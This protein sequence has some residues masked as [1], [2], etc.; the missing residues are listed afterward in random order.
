MTNRISPQTQKTVLMIAMGVVAAS[1]LAD[2]FGLN[3]PNFLTTKI[4]GLAN[5]L[6]IGA[7][8]ILYGLYQIKKGIV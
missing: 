2:L 5:L 7:G 1:T 4:G 3:I 6:H 8:L